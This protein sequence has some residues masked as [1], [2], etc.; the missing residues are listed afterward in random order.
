MHIAL[1]LDTLTPHG[2]EHYGV[3]LAND[4]V[5]RGHTVTLAHGN[6]GGPSLLD[7]VH[8]DVRLV[9]L[10]TRSRGGLGEV[11][12]AWSAAR[13]LYRGLAGA[14]VVHTIM[15][16]SGMVAWA[17]ARLRGIPALYSPMC[18]SGIAGRVHRWLFTS[19]YARRTVTYF[20]APSSYYAYDLETNLGVPRDRIRLCR[21]GVDTERFVPPAQPSARPGGLT[22]GICSRLA[23]GKGLEIAVEA[24]AQMDPSLGVRLEIAGAGPERSALESL[25]ASTAAR[26]GGDPEAVRFLGRV[27][28]VR[29]AL[30][31]F[32]VYLQTS[33]SPNLGLSALEAM[34]Y[35]VPLFIVARDP[36]EVR[37]AEDTLAGSQA[38]RVLPA[39]PKALAEQIETFCET[40][41][42]KLPLMRRAA[43]ATAV[44]NYDRVD[45]I[46]SLCDTYKYVIT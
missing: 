4:L 14:D 23:P 35:G 28:D 20:L 43:R 3:A 32:D 36:E 37:M 30:A 11:G 24:V 10:P 15:P 17:V 12:Y 38:G 33:R 6:P 25:A 42:D 22:L 34:A 29:T 9:T 19:G 46:N 40:G 39:D 1:V 16:A 13:A 7:R 18:L 21:L 44:D 2:A 45:H 27:S 41:L 26:T 5:G 8:S 31:R